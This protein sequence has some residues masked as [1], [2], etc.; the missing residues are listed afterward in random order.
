MHLMETTA[1]LTS[2]QAPGPLPHQ[3]GRSPLFEFVDVHKSFGPIDVLKGI[4]L[5]V[6]PG[7]TV[8]IVGN[9]GT[10]KSILVKMLIGLLVPDK[11]RI[12]FDGNEVQE[13]NEEQWMEVRK[14]VSMV[15]QANALFD[16]ETVLGNITYPMR[17]HLDLPEEEMRRRTAE[18]LS[19]VLLP[20]IE[21]RYP[22]ELSGGM[23]KRVGVARAIV[24]APNVILYDEPTAGL[25]PVSTTVLDEM[26]RRFQRERG[27]TS[28]VITHDL[29]SAM[30]V[31]DRVALLNEGRVWI[32]DTPEAIMQSQDPF[33]RRFF[34][35]YR[36]AQEM[37]G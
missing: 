9:S 32:C 23:R 15:F 10:G 30:N 22:T 12:F 34:E 11:G 37:L 1:N 16:S 4:N 25:D 19:W 26:V 28:I 5:Q 13:Y 29:K 7:E 31:G 24:M 14:Q 8:S 21:D 6:F 33:V 20:G 2:Q 35:G 17:Q 27:V 36:L 18:V 3:M